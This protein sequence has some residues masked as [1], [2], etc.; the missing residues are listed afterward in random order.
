MRKS[1]HNIGTPFEDAKETTLTGR[2]LLPWE[3]KVTD[4]RTGKRKFHGAFTGGFEAGYKNTC[5]SE[6]GFTPSQFVSSRRSRQQ[7]T[8]DVRQFMDAEDELEIEIGGNLQ[9]KDEFQTMTDVKKEE[10][11]GVKLYRLLVQSEVPVKRAV[12]GPAMPPPVYS[13]EVSAVKT[14]LGGLGY[15]SVATRV[16]TQKPVTNRVHSLFTEEAEYEVEEEMGPALRPTHTQTDHLAGFTQAAAVQPAAKSYPPP[17]VPKDYNPR[18]F[19][20]NFKSYPTFSSRPLDPVKR[21]NILEPPPQPALCQHLL[22]AS[23][24]ERIS[25][26]KSFVRSSER[27][28]TPTSCELNSLPFSDD[29]KKRDRL[30]RYICT[31]DGK[32]LGGIAPMCVSH[33]QLMTASQL[34]KEEEEFAAIYKE[35][36]G[37]DGTSTATQ[38]TPDITNRRSTQPWRPTELLCVRFNVP[39]PKGVPAPE[40]RRNDAFR[41]QVL[42]VVKSSESKSVPEPT[43]RPL[44]LTDPSFHDLFKSIFEPEGSTDPETSLDL[45]IGAKRNR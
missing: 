32:E 37:K 25:K 8:Q 21:Q 16:E 34:D 14:D 23:D 9:P 30:Y 13:S 33:I 38:R 26:L 4:E 7:V 28:I 20:L 27:L 15:V 6:T 44:L 31:K 41:Q 39:E 18:T 17:V 45:P 10:G 40:V 35:I 24:L 42:P 2:G 12:Y 5:G 29:L 22:S 36:K 1:R 11:V 19:L 43:T 3:Q